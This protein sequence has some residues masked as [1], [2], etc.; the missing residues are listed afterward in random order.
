MLSVVA[1]CV[2]FPLALLLNSKT[3]L[4]IHYIQFASLFGFCCF[5]RFLLWIV[6]GFGNVSKLNGS[7]TFSHIHTRYSIEETNSFY[8]F[9][10]S[11]H[12]LSTSS[13][14]IL[15]ASIV[16]WYFQWVYMAYWL[17]S[18]D[19]ISLIECYSYSE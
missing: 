15:A 4:F 5:C 18:H 19:S 13:F 17:N 3:N 16:N 10:F 12:R 14:N 8:F 9:L 11:P 6:I 2:F 1:H 7:I